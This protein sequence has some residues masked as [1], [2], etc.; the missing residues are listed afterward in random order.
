MDPLQSHNYSSATWCEQQY[1][2]EE[3]KAEVIVILTVFKIFNFCECWETMAMWTHSLVLR[4]AEESKVPWSFS[5]ISFM[6]KPLLF[7]ALCW[8]LFSFP[9][10]LQKYNVCFAYQMGK[11]HK[12]WAG[13]LCHFSTQIMICWRQEVPVAG[14]QLSPDLSLIS[15]G[16][17]FPRMLRVS[18]AQKILTLYTLSFTRCFLKGI[19]FTISEPTVA[20]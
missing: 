14:L 2:R 4:R 8:V 20:L 19:V 15:H 7:G 5:F 17:Y 1:D 6:V 10:V 9:H 18:L 13:R 11:A 12:H 16:P 3:V